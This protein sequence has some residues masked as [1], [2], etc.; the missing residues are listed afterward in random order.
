MVVSGAGSAWQFGQA[1]PA[2]L[3]TIASPL[4]EGKLVQTN[5]VVLYIARN[6]LQGAYISYS[7]ML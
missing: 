6:N 1:L 3:T 7:M 5:K 4:A 2:P